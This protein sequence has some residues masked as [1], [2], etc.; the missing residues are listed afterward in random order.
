M[1]TPSYLANSMESAEAEDSDEPPKEV[2]KE[3]EPAETKFSRQ[4]PKLRLSL[5]QKIGFNLTSLIKSNAKKM[6]EL[7]PSVSELASRRSSN[8]DQSVIVS[9]KTLPEQLVF[10]FTDYEDYVG[11]TYQKHVR[12]VKFRE[13]LGKALKDPPSLIYPSAI[14]R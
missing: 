1:T 14:N 10:A 6:N 4:K 12:L 2:E 11:S 13:V 7:L 3:E 9:N 5:T 8:S